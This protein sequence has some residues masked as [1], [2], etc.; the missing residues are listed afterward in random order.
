MR[1]EL[2]AIEAV[3]PDFVGVVKKRYQVLQHIDWLA[4]VGRRTLAEQ[5]KLSERVIRT[6][7][8]F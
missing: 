2:S 5:L 3:A 8:D 4:P 7:T 1:D 6:E